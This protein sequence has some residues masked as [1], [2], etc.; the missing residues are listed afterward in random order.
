MGQ[1]QNVLKSKR[2]RIKDSKGRYLYVTICDD[3]EIGTPCELWVTVFDEN[4]AAEQNVKTDI[5][6]VATLFTEAREGGVPYTK[7]VIAMENVCYS[8]ASNPARILR[9]LQ[10]HCTIDHAKLL[11][12]EYAS[13]KQEVADVV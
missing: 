10:T 4:K 7:L 1:K 13:Q 12:F 2:Y 6:T 5:T 3:P 11:E 8:K 9:L